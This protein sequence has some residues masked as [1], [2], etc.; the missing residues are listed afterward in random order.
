MNGVEGFMFL[1]KKFN[2]AFPYLNTIAKFTQ[3]VQTHPRIIARMKNI[4]RLKIQH[5]QA[6][7]THGFVDKLRI[8]IDFTVDFDPVSESEDPVFNGVEL[9]HFDNGE[10]HLFIELKAEKKA[11]EALNAS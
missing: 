1:Y 6:E 7:G 8:P 9:V 11:K 4:Q 5:V 3:W 2:K 10:N